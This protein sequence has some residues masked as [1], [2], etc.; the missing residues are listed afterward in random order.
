MDESPERRPSFYTLTDNITHIIPSCRFPRQEFRRLNRP[1]A[2]NSAGVSA[3]LKCDDFVS[4]RED[5]EMQ[6]QQ[7]VLLEMFAR[8]V[9]FILLF[10]QSMAEIGLESQDRKSTRLNSSHIPLSRMPSSA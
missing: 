1:F 2:E 4:S 7:T 5:H 3:V 10:C 6:L 9:L 8:Q